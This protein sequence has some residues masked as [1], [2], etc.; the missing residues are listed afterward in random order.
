MVKIAFSNNQKKE[1]N[2]PY[3]VVMLSAFAFTA[4]FVV[5]SMFLPI[6][7]AVVDIRIVGPLRDDDELNDWFVLSIN[8][9]PVVEIVVDLI[10]AI[11]AGVRVGV[12]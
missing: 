1:K 5:F 9:E 11:V 8:G 3:V 2:V 4:T 12:G 7:G 10:G 6:A